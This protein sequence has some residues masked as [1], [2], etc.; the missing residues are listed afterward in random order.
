MKILEWIHVVLVAYLAIGA[1]LPS[2]RNYVVVSSVVIL[3][4]I[5][6]GICPF[7]IGMGYPGDSFT[8][9]LLGPGGLHWFMRIFWLNNLLVSYRTG[10][11]WNILLLLG[12]ELKEAAR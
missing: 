10:T 1:F 9:A 11:I 8:E 5:L 12:Y 7:N 3:S 4:W 6:M 2:P